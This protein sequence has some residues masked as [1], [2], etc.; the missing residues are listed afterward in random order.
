MT[1][2][3]TGVEL[4]AFYADK[5]FWPE[6][7]A[8]TR[9]HTWHDDEEIFVDGVSFDRDNNISEIA[10]NAKVQLA[11]GIVFGPKWAEGDGPS[12]EGYFKQWRRIQ[13][14]AFLAVTVSKDR[15][16]ELRQLLA[17]FGAKVT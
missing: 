17:D 13:N 2:K 14:T 11:G 4:K 10:D 6:D 8:E 15:E 3:T 9:D 7:S 1:V 12:F 5:T 16:A